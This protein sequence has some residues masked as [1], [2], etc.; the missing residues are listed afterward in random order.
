MKN[1]NTNTNYNEFEKNKDL[2]L[3]ESKF[4]YLQGH[5]LPDKDWV[6]ATEAEEGQAAA[7]SIVDEF[8]RRYNPDEIPNAENN[9]DSVVFGVRRSLMQGPLNN[10]NAENI[11]NNRVSSRLEY[12]RRN[13]P[14]FYKYIIDEQVRAATPTPPNALG[15][16]W[17]AMTAR[18][19]R[20][21]NNISREMFSYNLRAGQNYNTLLT[22]PGGIVPQIQGLGAV[23]INGTPV[24]FASVDAAG[25][26][27]TVTTFDVNVGPGG[28]PTNEQVIVEWFKD[29]YI[30]IKKKLI[31]ANVWSDFM[32]IRPQGPQFMMLRFRYSLL[33]RINN[34]EKA[35][36]SNER[37]KPQRLQTF[38]DDDSMTQAL[39]D[40][41]FQQWVTDNSAPIVAAPNAIDAY[42]NAEALRTGNPALFRRLKR[43]QELAKQRVQRNTLEQMLKDILTPN[44]IEQLHKS[45]E[46]KAMLA[47]LQAEMND[48]LE[49]PEV[50]EFIRGLAGRT[51]DIDN[52]TNDVKRWEDSEKVILATKKD[53]NAKYRQLAAIPQ[54]LID[55]RTAIGAAGGGRNS[56]EA[57]EK[58]NSELS[59]LL[60]QQTKLQ[61]ELVDNVW[62]F[63]KFLQDQTVPG[64]NSPVGPFI[65]ALN[66]SAV[67]NAPIGGVAPIVGNRRVLSHS[68]LENRP[69]NENEI[70][71]FLQ[72]F[73]DLFS[74]GAFENT[75]DKLS[76]GVTGQKL[77]IQNQLQAAQAQEGKAEKMDARGLLYRLVERD[78][79]AKGVTEQNGIQQKSLY[80]TNILIAK[81]RNTDIYGQT[82][83]QVAKTIEGSF[84][85]RHFRSDAG[86]LLPDGVL[87]VL[88]AKDI[89]SHLA[90]EPGFEMFHNLNVFSSVK[91]LRKMMGRYGM[92]DPRK[93][94]ELQEKIGL[95][96]S[97]VEVAREGEGVGTAVR[98]TREKI[99]D[100]LHVED[101][102]NRYS[103]RKPVYGKKYR[104]KSEEA[105]LLENMMHQF[106]LLESEL[107]SKRRLAN[108]EE[109]IQDKVENGE[110]VNRS[111][112]I[113]KQLQEQ[114]ED[115]RDIDT[116]VANAVESD[117]APFRKRLI[118]S[119][120]RNNFYDAMEETEGMP[121]DE[122]NEYLASKGFNERVRSRGLFSLR[123]RWWT[124]KIGGTAVA[125][126]F[127][128]IA[129][130]AGG[131]KNFV[132]WGHSKLYNSDTWK[133]SN[134]VTQEQWKSIFRFPFTVAGSVLVNYPSKILS[135]IPRGLDK[136]A[137]KS[138]NKSY[139]KMNRDVI[140]T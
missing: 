65:A 133:K 106:A 103:K 22:G 98:H 99:A 120:L 23:V 118:F 132:K 4:V 135:L 12:V 92:A 48:S 82:N 8:D 127:K 122:R 123:T 81:S 54:K 73:S 55:Q 96:I 124:R 68:A 108:I 131:V 62:P 107:S 86:N 24:N 125:L 11:L 26:P 95:F 27:N 3:F 13:A 51:D 19:W 32:A 126:P 17:N 7:E 44:Q 60:D 61:I 72:T 87:P 30:T 112:T 50:R 15:S 69:K 102:I 70:N 139:A 89:L 31:K 40:A 63:I 64:V 111:E 119:Q 75:F 29:D 97:G 113:L 10:L 79:K 104:V 136:M 93:L 101:L 58:L 47:Y 41:D 129:G 6:E 20:M 52:L 117:H 59:A 49:G 91:D 37:F 35:K 1:K 28:A 42:A 74:Q 67:V 140:T 39:Q 121:S 53:F 105:P 116:S 18:R 57:I 110:A 78:L 21:E 14:E 138:T 128:A 100:T 34:E 56:A 80:A 45:D 114:T 84:L 66:G 33:N 25:N 130:V 9:V 85:G 5:H 137:V 109:E 16:I 46:V 90:D 2:T 94:R 77:K 134:E 71:N 76:I 43:Q 115:S 38:L 88:S 36:L 83:K